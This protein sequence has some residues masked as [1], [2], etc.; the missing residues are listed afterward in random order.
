VRPFFPGQSGR[1]TH[2][3]VSGAGVTR[4]APNRENA[5][6]LIEF[7][8]EDEAQRLFAEANQEYPVKPGIPWSATLRGWGDFE[9]DALDLTRLGELNAE[10]VRIFDRVGWR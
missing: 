4:N 1:G 10:A 7:L 3:N 6:R 2:V 8:S 5:I 9:A